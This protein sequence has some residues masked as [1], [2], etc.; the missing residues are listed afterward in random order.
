MSVAVAIFIIDMVHP[1]IDPR[2][3]AE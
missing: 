1:L 3:R 2:V